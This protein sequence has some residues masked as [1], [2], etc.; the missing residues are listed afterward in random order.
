[1]V[2]LCVMAIIE[3]ADFTVKLKWAAHFPKPFNN[4]PWFVQLINALIY[5][6]LR[7]NDPRK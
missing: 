5:K 2:I 4:F 7:F 3:D 1:M 6:L